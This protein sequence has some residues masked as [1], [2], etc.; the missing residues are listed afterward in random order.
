MALL[1]VGVSGCAVL[2]IGS[3]THTHH[4][5]DKE[6]DRKVEDLTKRVEAIENRQAGGI[7]TPPAQ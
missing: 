6:T 1:V 4:Y 5:G 7:M 3:N 2:E